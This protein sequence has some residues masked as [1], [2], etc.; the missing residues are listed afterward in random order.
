M[1]LDKTILTS[2]LYY[3]SINP[4]REVVLNHLFFTIGNGCTWDSAS[5]KETGSYR[6]VR[7]DCWWHFPQK[8]C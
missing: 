6:S 2:I 3:P 7:G 5:P 4:T 8:A 1:T